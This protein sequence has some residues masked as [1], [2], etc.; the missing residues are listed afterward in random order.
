MQKSF[1]EM[2]SA[3][4]FKPLP[5]S[6][7]TLENLL[8][9]ISGASR[10]ESKPLSKQK[11]VFEKILWGISETVNARA[12]KPLSIVFSTPE[13]LLIGI[14]G[15]LGTKVSHFLSKNVF[16]ENAVGYLTNVES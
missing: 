8:V 1:S 7:N 14:T 12:F 13:N 9:S 5:F 10:N 15:A 3:R 2:V 11:C 6:F 4:A 16:W